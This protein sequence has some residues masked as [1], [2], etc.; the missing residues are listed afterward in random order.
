MAAQCGVTWSN[1]NEQRV[2]ERHAPRWR[3]D[4]FK[5]RRCKR[6]I[7]VPIKESTETSE[8]YRK[9][10]LV[11]L[12]FLPYGTNLQAELLVI[13]W[14]YIL[15]FFACSHM[16][17]ERDPIPSSQT[18][19]PRRKWRGR[20]RRHGGVGSTESSFWNRRFSLLDTSCI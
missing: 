14:D 12:I 6:K 7:V 3:Q 4:N 9:L 11:M 1:G 2:S 13:L 5:T 8:S 20:L 17:Y 15:Q 10:Y 19:S 16:F 18:L